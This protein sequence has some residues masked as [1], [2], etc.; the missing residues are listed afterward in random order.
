MA[1]A[2]IANKLGTLNTTFLDSKA[3]AFLGSSSTGLITTAFDGSDPTVADINRAFTNTL[4]APSGSSGTGYST[5]GTNTSIGTSTN[6]YIF[7]ATDKVYKTAVAISNYTTSKLTVTSETNFTSDINCMCLLNTGGR[8]IPTVF[9]TLQALYAWYSLFDAVNW[10]LYKNNQQV[11]IQVPDFTSTSTLTSLTFTSFNLQQASATNSGL[12]TTSTSANIQLNSQKVIS[13]GDS[14]TTNIV[15]L[16]NYYIPDSLKIFDS[17]NFNPY[18]AR[19]IIHLFIIL[20]QYNIAVTYFNSL[21]PVPTATPSLLDDFFKLL[22]AFNYNVT[23]T[24]NGVYTQILNALNTRSRKYTENQQNITSLDNQVSD[25]KDNIATDSAKLNSRMSYQSKSK[26]YQ[27]VAITMLIIIGAGASILYTVPLE[28]KQKLSGG[29]TLI[30]IAVLTSI[31]LQYQSNSVRVKEGF[32]TTYKTLAGLT[33]QTSNGDYSW[34]SSASGY[35][36]SMLDQ[37]EIYLNNTFLLTSSLDSYHIYG[38]VNYAAQRELQFFGDTK[39]SLSMKDRGLQDMYNISY[40]DQVRFTALMNLAISLSLI[41]AVTITFTLA[42]ENFPSVKK[43]IFVIGGCLALISVTLYILEISSRVHTKPKQ[44]YW[45][46][47]DVK[48]LQSSS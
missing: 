24:E 20:I 13:S 18:V 30:I 19:R 17:T 47:G 12:S 39:T 28:Y 34:S 7:D 27:T 15:S 23:D 10:K 9:L 38:N 21:N 44:L 42:V 31:I 25:L 29:G 26:I 33:S 37:C 14:R 4:A 8:T 48:Q 36:N 2:R 3:S 40:M 41:I 1:L 16:M 46:A 32:Y 6:I 22:Q 35:Y 43:A 45:S 5:L 11:T